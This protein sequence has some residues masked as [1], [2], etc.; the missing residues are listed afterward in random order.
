MGGG[1]RAVVR[2]CADRRVVGSLRPPPPSRGRRVRV[3]LEA[4][5][6]VS[7]GRDP[8][9]IAAIGRAFSTSA[10]LLD[11][12]SDPDHHRAVFTLAADRDDLTDALGAGRARGRR[13]PTAP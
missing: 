9:A 5:P 11:V 6:N 10:R 1:T 8:A 7:E 13:A 12:H 4:V 3:V 2:K